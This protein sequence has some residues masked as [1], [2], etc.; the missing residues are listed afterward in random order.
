MPALIDVEEL[1]R[2]SAALSADLRAAGVDHVLTGSLLSLAAGLPSSAEELDL[3]VVV[4][5]V[6]E[7]RAVFDIALRHGFVGEDRESVSRV[8]ARFHA[9][10]R[11][12]TVPLDVVIPVLPFHAVIVQRSRQCEVAGVSVLLVT[13]DDL[14]PAKPR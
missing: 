2:L 11:C 6:R 1:T 14:A 7:L 12:G 10:M 5:S 13:T 3:G 8:G 9:A 4:P